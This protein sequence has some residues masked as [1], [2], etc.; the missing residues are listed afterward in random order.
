M[1]FTGVGSELVGLHL[2]SEPLLN[3]S[4]PLSGSANPRQGKQSLQSQPGPEVRASDREHQRHGSYSL[5]QLHM[6]PPHVQCPRV[7]SKVAASFHPSWILIQELVECA[8]VPPATPGPEAG[9]GIVTSLHHLFCISPYFSSVGG[10]REPSC[11][12]GGI[13][14]RR[15]HNRG[16]KCG[17]L[18]HWLRQEP[19]AY[20]GRILGAPHPLHNGWPLDH[21]AF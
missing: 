14:N 10:P 6:G 19:Q 4:L 9:T 21:A 11:R 1:V 17:N 5:P 20:S 7:P 12:A 13:Q 8:T 2:K 18:G 16:Q 3:P 15:Q